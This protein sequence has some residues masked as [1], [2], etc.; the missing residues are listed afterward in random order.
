M[1]TIMQGETAEKSE[2]AP[3]T[4]LTLT[5]RTALVTG[6]GSGF[7]AEI[8][9]VFA[10][11]GANVIAFDQHRQSVEN[12]SREISGAGLSVLPI[13]GDVTVSSDLERAVNVAL[14]HFGH[15]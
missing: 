11:A 8:S 7:G 5:G 14:H 3:I 10:G 2:V 15:L 6:A 1:Q 12:I 13:A 9:R 4:P